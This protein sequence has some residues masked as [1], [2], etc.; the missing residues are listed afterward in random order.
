MNSKQREAAKRGTVRK[1]G[2]ALQDVFDRARDGASNLMG[3]LN[4]APRPALQPVPAAN[5]ARR[6]RRTTRQR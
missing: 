4:P 2:E 3:L 1:I 6:A 5:P